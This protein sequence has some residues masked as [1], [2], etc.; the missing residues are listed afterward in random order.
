M[1]EIVNLH[2]DN[3]LK[4]AHS[5]DRLRRPYLFTRN[6]RSRTNYLSVR[7]LHSICATCALV[8]FVRSSDRLDSFEE[9]LQLFDLC[10]LPPDSSKQLQILCPKSVSFVLVSS[11]LVS[12]HKFQVYLFWTKR[13]RYAR[14]QVLCDAKKNTAKEQKTP[15]EV[16][17][18]LSY[19][20]PHERPHK[21]NL[22]QCKRQI[23]TARKPIRG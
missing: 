20:T 2:V 3:I 22:A 11:Y 1:Q 12:Q 7:Y 8:D 5:Q 21:G 4:R 19:L 18:K 15:N 6:W 10:V 13:A 9:P 23:T 14:S 17:S 16:K